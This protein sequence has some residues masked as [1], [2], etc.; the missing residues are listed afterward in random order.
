MLHRVS[1]WRCC[2]GPPTKFGS[3]TSEEDGWH[4]AFS[5][6]TGSCA[7]FVCK[8]PC[9]GDAQPHLATAQS[10]CIQVSCSCRAQGCAPLIRA[11]LLL[12]H[13]TRPLFT[14]S[15]PLIRNAELHLSCKQKS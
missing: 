5:M 4:S 1:Q 13:A 6:A 7:N 8:L 3:L 11:D 9:I 10:R 2:S 12:F 15:H 14:L